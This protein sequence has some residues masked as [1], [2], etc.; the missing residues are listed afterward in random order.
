[1]LHMDKEAILR[2]T[3]EQ[4][5]TALM[6]ESSGHDWWHVHRV[7]KTAVHIWMNEKASFFTYFHTQDGFFEPRDHL[8]F[9]H[10]EFQW[11]LSNR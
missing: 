7:W 1:M 5:R 9:P 6:G 4:V 10:G 2:A 3:A 11:A 8:T